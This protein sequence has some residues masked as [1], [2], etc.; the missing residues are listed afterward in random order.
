MEEIEAFQ[1]SP[2]KQPRVKLLL[3]GVHFCLQRPLCQGSAVHSKHCRN[4]FGNTQHV[5][6]YDGSVKQLEEER[7][8]A[9]WRSCDLDTPGIFRQLLPLAQTFSLFFLP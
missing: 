2:K 4:P 1:S 9:I 3:E 5:I 6:L 7:R 8:I